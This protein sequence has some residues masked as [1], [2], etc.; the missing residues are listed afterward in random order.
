MN[1]FK[2]TWSDRLRYV[3]PVIAD[4]DYHIWG[5]SPIWGDDGRVHV[6]CSRIPRDRGFD[7]WW[8]TSQIAHYVA[9]RPEGP[10]ELVEV[11]LEP[12]Q[13][14]PGTWDCG[15]QH[16]P[17][18]TRVGDLFVLSY[19]SSRSTPE[20]RD[21][22]SQL[23]AMMTANRINGPW[24][25]HGVV[26]PTPTHEQVPE[27]PAGY[28]GGTDNP[29]LLHH[30]DGRFYLYYRIKFPGLEGEN[31]YGVAIADQLTGPYT[32]HP[33]RVIDNPSYVEDPYVFVHDGL[34]YMLV[35]DNRRGTGRL[36]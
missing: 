17:S 18:I 5:C 27:V 11:L 20:Q 35:T 4:A 26:L 22:P 32:F 28:D 31:T 15:T 21:R 7:R 6:F 1:A 9:D 8:A 30:P 34:I 36:L 16:N 12:G 10:Y 23:I 24:T 14:L 2:Q 13:S 25:K 29:A 3:G 33:R 19:H